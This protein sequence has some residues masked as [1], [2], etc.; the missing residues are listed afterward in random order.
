MYVTHIICDD[1]TREEKLSYKENNVSTL[2]NYIPKLM[3]HD[4]VITEIKGEEYYEDGLIYDFVTNTYISK[5]I[6]FHFRV[7]QKNELINYYES[8]YLN[9]LKNI[10]EKRAI[11]KG[12]NG[13]TKSL[14]NRQLTFDLQYGFPLIK[15]ALNQQ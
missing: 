14:L 12:R 9:I 8:Q 2:T 1:F 13:I 5:L 7:F 15:T 10:S 11:I 4:M 6:H 3:C